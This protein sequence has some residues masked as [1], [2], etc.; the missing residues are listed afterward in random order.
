MSRVREVL[1]THADAVKFAREQAERAERGRGYCTSVE[2]ALA[3]LA[4]A[5][6]EEQ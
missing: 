6:E 4:D 1:D 3:D 5:V 2:S